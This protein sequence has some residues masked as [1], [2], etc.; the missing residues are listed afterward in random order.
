MRWMS[1]LRE[2][3]DEL[4][5]WMTGELPDE[6]ANWPEGWKDQLAEAVEEIVDDD[7][8]DDETV[9]QLAEERVRRAHSRL[10]PMWE[11]A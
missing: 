1:S 10:E 9:L 7:E 3:R 11:A 8:L 5:M 4:Q 6:P 2:E